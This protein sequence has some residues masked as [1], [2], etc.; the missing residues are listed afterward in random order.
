MGVRVQLTQSK[1]EHVTNPDQRFLLR[2]LFVKCLQPSSLFRFGSPNV[3]LSMTSVALEVIEDRS[4]DARDS[5][6][7]MQRAIG[8]D[9]MA[10]LLYAIRSLSGDDFWGF[11]SSVPHPAKRKTLRRDRIRV[12]VVGV[13]RF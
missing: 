11:C 12:V 9:A 8:V 3:D 1:L 2:G 13:L 7:S 6:G 10:R 5:G 4:S